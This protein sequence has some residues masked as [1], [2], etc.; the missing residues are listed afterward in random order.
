MKADLIVCNQRHVIF[1]L[2][3][4]F[5]Q[6]NRDRFDKVIIVFTDMKVPDLDYRNYMQDQ[7]EKDKITFLDC[8]PVEGDE[9]WR[10]KA[11]N[12]AL[13][14][15]EAEWIYFTEQDFLPNERFWKEIDALSNRTDV[16][17]WYQGGR[18]HPCCIFIKR[19]LLN[20]THKDFGVTKDVS[21]HFG[22]FQEDLDKK[23]III[24]VIHPT[25]GEHMNGLSQNMY[26]LQ[27]GL[28]PNYQPGEF[29]E[30]CRKCLLLDNLHPDFRE[31]FSWYLDK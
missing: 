1:P 16:F 2:W 27:S 15:S 29:K 14:V 22:K 23:D 17:G 13:T 8:L 6:D 24:G 11:I 3:M 31:L 30:Y 4:E 5:I 25:L 7:M 19:E 12:M 9:D 18:L 26:M 28:E 10:N 21:D 20:R